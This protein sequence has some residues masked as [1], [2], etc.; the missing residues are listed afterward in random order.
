MNTSTRRV[1]TAA[2]SVLI[3]TVAACAPAEVPVPGDG[4]SS[5]VVPAETNGETPI[6]IVVGD[7]AVRGTVWHNPTGRSLLARLPVTVR[8]ADH[9]GQEK[10]GALPAP[11]ETD[12]MPTGAD[13]QT[14]DLGYFAPSTDLVLYYRDAPYWAGIARIGRID[15]DLSVVADA[16]DGTPVTVARAK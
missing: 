9:R 2:T 6:R 13:P 16:P 10:G 14:G 3:I 1:R 5:A 7:R 8:L 15:G 4:A 12:G 11:L